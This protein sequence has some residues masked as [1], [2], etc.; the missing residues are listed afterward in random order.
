[1]TISHKRDSKVIKVSEVMTSYEYD[2]MDNSINGAVIELNGRY[3]TEGRVYNEECK[4]LSF[5]IR[6]KGRVVVDGKET[7]FTD[8]DQILIDPLEKYYWEGEAT[9]FISCTP[10]WTPEQHKK[11]D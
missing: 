2:H 3:P 10:A 7:K 6:G 4:E 5:V 8:G 11:T 9:L 1:M